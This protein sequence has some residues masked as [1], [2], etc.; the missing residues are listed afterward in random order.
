[1]DQTEEIRIPIEDEEEEKTEESNTLLKDLGEKLKEKE[2]LYLRTLADFDNYRRRVERE[3]EK[4]NQRTKKDLLREFLEIVDN[5]E[6]AVDYEGE[7]SSSLKEGVR[8]IYQ[9][10]L[11]IFKRNG[12]TPLESIGKD[13]DPRFHEAVGSVESEDFPSGVVALELKK[14]YLMGDELLRPSR[15]QVVK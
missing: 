3:K 13:F 4:S 7:G 5:L 8:A 6:R 2:D 11:D 1:M 15:V 9:Q 12:V 14:G 10:V